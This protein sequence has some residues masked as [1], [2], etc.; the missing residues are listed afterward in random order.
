M[1]RPNDNLPR[2]PLSAWGAMLL[3]AALL[4]N[5]TARPIIEMM[6]EKS[7][8]NALSGGFGIPLIV[9]IGIACLCVALMRTRGTFTHENTFVSL[10]FLSLVMV[11][12]SA[13]A[14]FGLA[15][16]GTW[17]MVRRQSYAAGLIALAL[18]LR[19]LAAVRGVRVV[20]DWVLT[21]DAWAAALVMKAMVLMGLMDGAALQVA[22]TIIRDV[23]GGRFV[24]AVLAE[25]GTIRNVSLT[26]VGYVAVV[27]AVTLQRPPLAPLLGL[28][29][30]IPILNLVR[31]AIMGV[32]VQT[33]HLVHGPVGAHLFE[34]LIAAATLVAIRI[35]ISTWATTGPHQRFT[36]TQLGMSTRSSGSRVKGYSSKRIS[37]QRGVS[38]LLQRLGGVQ[39]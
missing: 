14:W 32:D 17:A 21:V 27:A 37:A 12:S 7:L 23:E 6:Q 31:I 29:I 22:N 19:E 33:Y 13:F 15:V 30:V 9:W 11:P 1:T 5:G 4:V 39:S 8:A 18:G 24:L 3:P 16:W 35:A 26:V 38:D 2:L 25:C 34:A 28:L 20:G 36:E 10:G